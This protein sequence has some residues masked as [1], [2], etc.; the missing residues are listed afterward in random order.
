MR[1]LHNDISVEYRQSRV[2]LSPLGSC[3]KQIQSGQTPPKN[4]RLINAG[5]DHG[6]QEN[7]QMMH[8]ESVDQ[9]AD[10]VYAVVRLAAQWAL[11]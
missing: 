7:R 11:G 5:V 4:T 9:F 1:L 2:K 6:C 3:L 10:V 8:V